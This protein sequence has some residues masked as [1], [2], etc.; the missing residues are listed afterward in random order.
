MIH[1]KT[2]EFVTMQVSFDE[3]KDCRSRSN[4]QQVFTTKIG[5]DYLINNSSVGKETVTAYCVPR[6]AYQNEAF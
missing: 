6:I 5:S 2:V 1:D 3:K 4:K